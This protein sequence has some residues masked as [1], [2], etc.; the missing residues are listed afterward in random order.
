MTFSNKIQNGKKKEKKY[1]VKEWFESKQYNNK[2]NKR[3]S[4]SNSPQR[5]MSLNEEW[6]IIPRELEVEVIIHQNHIKHGPI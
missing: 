4:K 2:T 1:T 5:K 6:Y 3:I